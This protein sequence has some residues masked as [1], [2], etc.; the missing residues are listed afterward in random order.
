MDCKLG[1]TF[2][3][4]SLLIS[5][6][7]TGQEPKH[8]DA[9]EAFSK[10]VLEKDFG[11]ELKFHSRQV[12]SIV[13]NN[14]VPGLNGLMFMRWKGDDGGAE[15]MAS[16]QWFEKKEDLIAFYDPEKIRNP[17]KLNNVE[18][19]T[20]WKMEEDGF[21]GYMWTDGEHFLV[22]LGGSPPPPP[23]MMKAWLGLI[24]S[25]VGELE[26]KDDNVQGNDD[27]KVPKE[28]ADAEVAPDA[29]E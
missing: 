13:E 21:T 26:K 28:D 4:F 16:V 10:I 24:A 2:V 3:A 17:Y 15:V 27:N 25:N 11:D 14:R 1:W 7:S 29:K 6:N 22:T 23:E 19:T 5:V 9:E 8:L 18:K 12:V 20:L